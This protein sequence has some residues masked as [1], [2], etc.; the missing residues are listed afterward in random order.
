MAIRSGFFNSVGGDRKYDARRFAEYFAT[1]IGNGVFPN[2]SSNLQVMANND[3]TVTVS[4]GKAW[5][6]GYILINDDDYILNIEPADGVLN[7]IDR[8]VV[9]YD[10]VDREIKVAVKKGV[11]ASTPIA[12]TLQR[13]ADGYELAIANVLVGKGVISVSQADITDT[14]LN[15]ELCGVVSGV[16]EQVD[17]TTLYNQYTQGFEGSKRQFEQEFNSWFN[18]LQ[19]LLDEN[20]VGNLL[21]LIN[22]T[23]TSLNN[24]LVEAQLKH[25]D[26]KYGELTVSATN[27]DVED[28]YVNAEWKRKDNTTYAKSTFLGTSPKYNQIKVDYYDEEGLMVEKTITWALSYDDNDFI[29]K[30]EVI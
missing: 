7:R 9:R 12:P 13:S 28:I 8:I 25:D 23:E 10:V 16:V 11:Y 22:Q 1:F 21:N 18:N 29:Y 2:P 3:M 6:N 19:D 24:H 26:L 20:T 30:K 15:D 5:I 14:R 27:K 4:A 17:T